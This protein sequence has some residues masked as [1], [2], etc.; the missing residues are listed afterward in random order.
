[1]KIH[2]DIMSAMNKGE[3]TL[4]TFLDYSKAFDTTSLLTTGLDQ[5]PKDRLLKQSNNAHAFVPD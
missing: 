5:T 2:D 1:M 3:L 4:A